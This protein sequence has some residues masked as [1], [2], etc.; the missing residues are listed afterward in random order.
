MTTKGKAPCCAGRRSCLSC[1][2]PLTNSSSMSRVE[3][4][5]AGSFCCGPPLLEPAPAAAAGGGDCLRRGRRRRKQ[6]AMT[7]SATTSGRPPLSEASRSLRS[8][9]IVPS[10]GQVRGKTRDGSLASLCNALAPL[11]MLLI[12]FRLYGTKYEYTLL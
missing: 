4:L 1:G 2:A 3:R 9:I 7:R 12:G 11:G 10:R 8:L 5:S 6:M